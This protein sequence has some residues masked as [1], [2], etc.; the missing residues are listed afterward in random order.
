MDTQTVNY[1]ITQPQVGSDSGTW[2]TILNNGVMGVLDTILGGN[3]STSIT[4]ADVTLT[5]TQFQ[6]GVFIVNGTLTGA[7]SLILPLQTLVATASVGGKFIVVNNTQGA[8]AL[9]VKTAAANAT[10]GVAVVPQGQACN[11]YSDSINVGFD[12][13]GLPASVVAVNGNPT[14]QL[15]GTAGAVNANASLAV[16]YVG[17]QLY[18]C[19]QGG[20]AATAQWVNVAGQAAFNSFDM[21]KNLAFT[22]SVSG[23][24]LTVTALAASSNTT[25]TSAVPIIFQFR[26][27]TLTAGDPVIVNATAALSIS[28]FT[29]GVTFGAPNATPF[30]LWIAGFNNS[31]T[32]VLSLINCSSTTGVG[33]PSEAALQSGIGITS[34]ATATATFYTPNGV[35]VTSKA[36]RLLGYVEYGTGLVTAGTYN[37]AP[38]TVQL[39][40]PGVKK[41]GDPVQTVFGQSASNSSFSLNITPTSGP[42]LVHAVANPSIN[43]A[44]PAGNVSL[45][46]K[47]TQNGTAISTATFDIDTG[48]GFT[49]GAMTSHSI[50]TAPA[51][52]SA[53][54]YATVANSNSGTPIDVNQY[55][56]LTEIMG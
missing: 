37:N 43:F 8:F 18:L 49:Y 6:N 33:L 11:L 23:N 44:A 1:S 34:S 31:G 52:T 17:G 24:I 50:L 42:N 41:P 15:A 19:T 38:S 16:D 45:G 47:L 5:T 28:T 29:T 56:T 3:Y 13:T 20:T 35:T 46:S 9:T 32:V 54:A 27:S 55:I 36:W 14:G 2:G 12:N 51:T 30:R 7:H 4:S 48:G 40:G 53:V 22:A 25:P 39:F 10:S 26:D 21:P